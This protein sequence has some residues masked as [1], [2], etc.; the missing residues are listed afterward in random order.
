MSA[1]PW[2]AQARQLAL[3]LDEPSGFSPDDF[4]QGPSNAQ[5]C[6]ALANPDAWVNH[7]L[8]L[9]GEAGCGK[10]HLAAIWAQT[11]GALI[12]PASTLRTPIHPDHQAKRLVIEDIDAT[13]DPLA[14]LASLNIAHAA[15]QAV[16]LTSRVPPARL[17]LDPPDLASRLRASLIIAITPADDALLAL[18]LDRLMAKRQLRLNE[19]LRQYLLSHLPRQPGILREAV[20]RLDRAALARGIAPSRRLAEHILVDLLESPESDAKFQP[21]R[22]PNS[23]NF[24]ATQPLL[25]L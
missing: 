7:R 22:T 2:F 25:T 19:P 13:A 16:L 15:H 5:A 14:L 18:L 3:P 9:W 24:H 17:A 12:M 4:T 20:T 23:S 6:V 11:T 1:S 21:D 10:S 8:V